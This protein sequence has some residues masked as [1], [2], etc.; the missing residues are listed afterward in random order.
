MSRPRSQTALYAVLCALLAPG[1]LPGAAAIRLSVPRES[2]PLVLS[3]MR[4]ELQRITKPSGVALDW[5][6][7]GEARL[8]RRVS[9]RLIGRCMAVGG[10]DR[11]R[12]PLG[13][14]RVIDGRILPYVEVDCD[15]VRTTIAPEIERQDP[16]FREVAMGRALARALAHELRHALSRTFSHG[17]DGLTQERLGARDLL[18]GSYHLE[19]SDLESMAEL[20]R[21]EEQEQADGSAKDRGATSETLQDYSIDIGR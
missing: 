12:G 7:D 20:A 2:S 15:R 5:V 14:T 3:Q 17:R 8:G 1:L 9:V 11:A 6:A 21:R 18:H 10:A 16:A 19:R 4:K 13:W